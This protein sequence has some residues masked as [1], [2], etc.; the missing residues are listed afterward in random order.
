M[1]FG[2]DRQHYSL[3]KSRTWSV[4]M[5]A[6]HFNKMEQELYAFWSYSRY[7]Y[8]LWGKIE[9][10]KGDKVYINSY[11]G[12]FKPF[13][14]V[15]GEAGERLIKSLETLEDAMKD[16][17]DKIHKSYDEELKQFLPDVFKK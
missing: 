13:K 7:P 6:H 8:C 3:L 1:G 10:F 15:E 4:T 2:C 12:W 11:Q 14:I 9:K 17:I 5:M 16:N